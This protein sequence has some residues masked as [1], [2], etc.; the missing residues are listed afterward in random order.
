M[1]RSN[2]T[3]ALALAVIALAA[4]AL[5]P[6]AAVAADPKPAAATEKLAIEI[7]HTNDIHGYLRTADNGNGGAGAMAAKITAAREKAKTDPN[8][9]VLVLDAGDLQGGGAEDSF[10]RGAMMREYLLGAG[11]DA[12]VPGNHDFGYG[13]DVLNGMT[14]AF[15]AAGGKALAVNIRKM[16]G[17]DQAT[18]VCD[19]SA[20]FTIKGV[21]I[22]LVGATT[23]GTERMNLDENVAGLNFADPIEP[24]QKEVRELKKQGVSVCLLLSHV[25]FD[26]ARY[27]DDKKIAAAVKD[28]RAII[29]ATPTRCSTRRSWSRP[30]RP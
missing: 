29:A 6:V 10:S 19:G 16:Q 14:K 21:K 4:T 27:V 13:L 30:T 25:G 7:L 26:N 2:L 5:A 3:A 18:D 8:Y 17:G 22:G 9:A 24:V 11:Y 20:I 28:L 15:R 1:F 12:Y 23:P